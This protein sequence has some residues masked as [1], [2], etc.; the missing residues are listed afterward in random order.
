L[1]PSGRSATMSRI[2]NKPIEL[3]KGVTVDIQDTVLGQKVTVKGPKGTLERTFRPEIKINLEGNILTTTRSSNLKSVH[4]L[5]GTTRAH[6]NNMVV[7][8]TDGFKKVLLIS[9]VGFKAKA[10]GNK[11]TFNLGFSHDIKLD[12]PEGIKIATPKDNR[13]EVEG[14]DKELLGA[15]AQKIRMLRD[16]DPYKAK[17]VSYEGEVIRRKAGK[18]MTKGA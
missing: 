10:E 11:I 3:P 1:P 13:V 15:F 16:P 17:G 6:L 8:V 2:G 7:G 18:A 9:G 12:V 14:F 4:Q 5:H